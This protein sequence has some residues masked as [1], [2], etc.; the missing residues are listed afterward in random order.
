MKATRMDAERF[1]RLGRGLLK[2]LPNKA[3]FNHG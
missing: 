2:C 1:I 3:D